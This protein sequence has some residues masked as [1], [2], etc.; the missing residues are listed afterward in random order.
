MVE[1]NMMPLFIALLAGIADFTAEM[2]VLRSGRFGLGASAQATALLLALALSGFG[3]GAALARRLH[4][5]RAFVIL[6]IIAGFVGAAASAAPLWLAGQGGWWSSVAAPA[7]SIGAAFLFAIPSG[8]SIPLL[9]TWTRGRASRAGILVSAGALGSVAGAWAGG[10][11]G[12]VQAGVYLCSLAVLALNFLA[13]SLAFLFPG[14]FE[15][16]VH[17]E[18]DDAEPRGRSGRMHRKALPVPPRA[19]IWCAFSAGAVTIALEALLG[20][21]L[22]FFLGDCSDSLV[23]LLGAALLAISAGSLASGFLLKIVTPRTLCAILLTGLA[24]SGPFLLCVLEILSR[25]P[26]ISVPANLEDYIYARLF[27]LGLFVAPPLVLAGALSPVAFAIGR[28]DGSARASKLNFAYSAG[29]LAPALLVP[30]LLSLGFSTTALCGAVGIFIFPAALALYGIRTSPL[31]FPILA[32]ALLGASPVTTRVPPFRTQPSL[33]VLEAKEGPVGLAAAVLDRRRHEKTLFT[34]NFRAA[35][36][37]DENRYTRSLAHLPILLANTEPASA[38]IIAVGTGGT[39]GAA[40]RY[41]SL[42]RI[43]LIEISSEVFDLL[44][45]FSPASDALFQSGVTGS[46]AAFV[47]NNFDPRIRIVMDDGRRFAAREGELYDLLILEPLLP[48]TPAAFPFYTKEFYQLASRR[49]T[50]GGVL[51]QWIPMHAI[52]PRA[53]RS[54]VATFTKNFAHRALFLV[55]KSAILL[56]SNKPLRCSEARLQAALADPILAADLQRSGCASA[57]D[58]AAQCVL[59]TQGLAAFTTENPLSDERA[60]IER[61]GFMTGLDRIRYEL[62][63]LDTLIRAREAAATELYPSMELLQTGEQEARRNAGLAYLKGR[64]VLADHAPGARAGGENDLAALASSTAHPFAGMEGESYYSRR[65]Q[66]VGLGHLATND[67]TRALPEM[68]RCA[69]QLRDPLSILA[70]AVALSR[71]ARPEDAAL[72]AAVAIALDPSCTESLPPTFPPEARPRWFDDVKLLKQRA[73]AIV[74]KTPPGA[75]LELIAELLQSREPA[76]RVAA[77]RALIRERDALGFLVEGVASSALTRPRSELS[78]A[79]AVGRELYDPTLASALRRI[80]AATR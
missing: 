64:R 16:Y 75:E 15:G 31:V 51:T 33:E 11:F 47:A 54:L 37:G 77:R 79:L 70:F 3:I 32:G 66:S 17:S 80:E 78:A 21:L 40:T 42:K 60:S 72:E 9:Y 10:I 52:E 5:V 28:G 46:R 67:V 41:K 57:G 23:Y 30:F 13:G 55:G 71:A 56:G 62:E 53:F 35:A 7:A 25:T 8:A 68:E 74:T 34:N 24:L 63:N 14:A 6:R 65:M 45:W 73:A 19:A 50:D 38:A 44:K 58:I 36:T 29:A 1:R 69:R 48:D 61:I 12:P 20:R 26:W 59:G 18:K 2:L 4:G 22:P 49:L 76:D 27:F 39:A 43:D